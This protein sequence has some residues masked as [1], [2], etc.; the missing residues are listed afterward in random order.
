MDAMTMNELHV[1]YGDGTLGLHGNSFDYIFSYEKGGLE[2]LVVNAAEW[3]YRVP[4]LTF[5]RAT[6]D[7]DRGSHFSTQSAAWFGAD[8]FITLK[9]INVKID[10]KSLGLPTA[11]D[12]NRF[13]N[14]IFAKNVAITFGFLTA[15]T[16]Q[17]TVD[18]TYLVSQNGNITITV[19]YTGTTGLPELPALGLSFIMPEVADGFQYTGLS[20]ETYPDRQAGALTG[21]FDIVGLPLTPYLV[22]QEMGMHMATH[23]LT[24]KN[25]ASQQTHDHST[26]INRLTFNQHTQPFAFSVLPYTAIELESATHIEELPLPRRSV[27]TIYGAVRGV[28]GIDSWGTDVEPEYHIP[29]ETDH[30]FDFTIV[31]FQ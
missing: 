13:S 6:T 2:S 22:P 26:S 15:T 16:P 28:G 27:I 18:V 7:N 24:V 17:T 5:W 10:D 29:G 25:A 23:Y 14:E 20:G 4:K 21:T 30:A 3:L 1:V 19:N 11:P 12:N 31:P 8:M 9:D